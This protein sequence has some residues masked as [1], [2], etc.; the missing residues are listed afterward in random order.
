M[1]VPEPVMD[2]LSVVAVFLHAG[3][4]VLKWPLF[5][6]GCVLFWSGVGVVTALDFA[7]RRGGT[8][9][10]VEI[11]AELAARYRGVYA[12]DSWRGPLE[13]AFHHGGARVLVYVAS[14]GDGRWK[15]YTHVRFQLYG[16]RPPVRC[17]VYPDRMGPRARKLRGMQD[18]EIG[19]PEFDER[20]VI[21][22]DDDAEL[23]RLLSPAA[24]EQIE[25][26]RRLRDDDDVYVSFNKVSL[27]VRKPSLISDYTTLLR[28][29]QLAI[30]LYDLTILS[31]MEGIDVVADA[32]PP[33]VEEAIC[34]VCGEPIGT[35][36]VFCRRCKTPHHRECWEYYGACSTY[37]CL[38]E[39]CLPPESRRAKR[40][41]RQ[42]QR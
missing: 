9:P 10:H 34:Q 14:T 20:Y 3:L 26:L 19:S 12:T 30:G 1:K 38:E 32:P 15:Y 29:T 37:G 2:A 41:Q 35:D 24:Q 23:R 5:L 28:F 21:Q 13:V 36:V 25:R 7:R 27:V 4:I 39:R 6:W 8:H 17:E 22:G 31:S 33:K 18:I 11:Y 16:G 40:V 42:M